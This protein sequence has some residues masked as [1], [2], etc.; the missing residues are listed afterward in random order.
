MQALH[1]VLLLVEKAS[2]E[3]KIY[4][5]QPNFKDV[6]LFMVASGYNTNQ[7]L[8]VVNYIRNISIKYG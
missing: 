2:Y 7:F 5:D 1:H 6:G 3:G 8:K 4:K